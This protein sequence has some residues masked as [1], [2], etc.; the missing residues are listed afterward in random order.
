[1][2]TPRA[3]HLT[4]PEAFDGDELE[5]E[6]DAYR[7]LFRAKRLAVGDALRVVDGAGR[8]RAGRIEEVGRSSAVVVLGEVLPSLESA[9]RLHLLVGALRPER[10]GWLVEKATELGVAGVTFFAGERTPRDY[11]RA[12]LERWRRVAAAAVEQCGRSTVPT[13]SGVVPLAEAVD[14]AP[15]SCIALVPGAPP[16]AELPSPV[17]GSMSL[18]IGPEGGL[19]DEDLAL[20][21]E[22]GADRGRLGATILRVETAAVAAASFF[23]CR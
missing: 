15:S 13:I 6:G 3:T 23:L 9:L 20:L 16:L 4:T 18:V 22:R 1:M 14:D 5:I 8:A 11:G 17:E 10:A 21:A 12:K 7:H 19:G 2:S